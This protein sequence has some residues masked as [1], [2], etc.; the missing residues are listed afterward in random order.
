MKTHLYKITNLINGK[1]YI[2][3]SRNPR[4][5]F[6]QHTR[7]KYAIGNAIRKWGV[8]NFELSTIATGS[9]EYI[10]SIEDAAILSFSSSASDHGYNM[11]EGGSKPPSRKGTKWSESGRHHHTDE[12]K[13]QLSLK[14]RGEKHPRSVLSENDVRYIRQSEESQ[15]VLAKKFGVS[16]PAI[17]YARNG[18]SWKHLD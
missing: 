15:R 4:E 12:T 14:N 7:S 9:E 5:R 11:T 17:F 3:V 13:H 8:E 2:G 6:R 10:Y 1:C 16:N 18:K